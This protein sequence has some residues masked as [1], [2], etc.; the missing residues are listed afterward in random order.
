MQTW[1]KTSTNELI[2]GCQN[3]II[4]NSVTS[5]G[6]YAFYGCTNIKKVYN[7]SSLS[8]T[9][10]TSSNGHVAY[11]AGAIYEKWTTEGDYVIQ[12]MDNKRYV[13]DY[14]GTSSTLT[15]P[16][17]DG[18]TE[19]AFYNRNGIKSITIPNCITSIGESAFYGCASLTSITIPNSVTSI[20]DK[21]FNGCTGLTNITIPNS[22]TSIGGSAFS[23]CKLRDIQVLAETPATIYSNTFSGQSQY[24]TTLLVPYGCYDKYAYDDTYWYM[25]IHIKE[26]A[27]ATQNLS[28]RQAYALKNAATRSYIVYDAVNDAVAE[29]SLD[30]NIDDDNANHNWQV[31]EQDGK[32][33]I[34][35]IGA[36]K[37]LYA[38]STAEAASMRTAASAT[39]A[40]STQWKLSETPV[41]ISLS[42]GES[43]INIGNGGEWLFVLNPTLAVDEN[44]SAIEQ[45]DAITELNSVNAYSLEGTQVLSP[46]RNGLYVRAGQSVLVK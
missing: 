34:Y 44:V 16:N 40:T 20:G 45:L 7:H 27:A 30:A 21:T 42:T 29:I 25:F 39:A 9:K 38:T 32:T 35:N 11:Y 26:S 18:L 15:L 41:A 12:T 1:V 37:Y 22:V 24:H 10:G 43:G 28:P 46:R 23:G 13:C 3:T 33:Y 8:F 17:V 36:K 5:I 2:A 31:I 14:I 19:Y 4:P 6:R